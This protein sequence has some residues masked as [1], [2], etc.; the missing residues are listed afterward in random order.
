MINKGCQNPTKTPTLF[1]YK[2]VFGKNFD[3]LFFGFWSFA[4][5]N[6][7]RSSVFLKTISY[8]LPMI[9]IFIFTE[10]AIFVRVGVFQ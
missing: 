10:R 4:Y 9:V 7:W 1:E 6:P 8:I 2:N 5:I 3:K